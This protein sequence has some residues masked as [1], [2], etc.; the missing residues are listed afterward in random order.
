MSGLKID[1]DAWVLV[2][3]GEKALFLR[4]EGDARAPNLEVIGTLEP[5]KTPNR[6]AGADQRTHA[7][8]S[9]S[10]PATAMGAG[11]W[12]N[13]EKHRFAKEIALALYEAARDGAFS[14]LVV[15][16][17]P[18]TLGDLRKELHPEVSEKIIAEIAKSLT[19]LPAH[20]I[21]KAL[22]SAPH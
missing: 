13:Q 17:P 20:D 21:E 22:T 4:N 9:A 8:V 12:R 15:V 2:G 5:E 6:E 3:D 19:N 16:A 11:A 10:P 18:M 7:Q 1:H 14:Q